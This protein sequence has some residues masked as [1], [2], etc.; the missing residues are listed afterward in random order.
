MGNKVDRA[1]LGYLKRPSCFCPR[2][3]KF[4]LWTEIPSP[5][6]LCFGRVKLFQDRLLTKVSTECTTSPLATAT[7]RIALLNLCLPIRGGSMH[8][9]LLKDLKLKTSSIL[10]ISIRTGDVATVIM[11]PNSRS[12]IEFWEGSHFN[13]VNI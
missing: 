5:K 12:E 13:T 9:R 11:R 7:G 10:H 1:T 8:E 3:K 6:R 4:C 2:R